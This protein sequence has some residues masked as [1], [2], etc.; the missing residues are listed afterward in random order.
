MTLGPLSL[1]S[2]ALS[3]NLLQFL[4]TL[5]IESLYLRENLERILGIGTQV[6]HRVDIGVATEGSTVGSAV[7]LVGRTVG[8]LG[9]LTHHTVTDDQARTLL[10]CLGL[11]DGLADLVDV[12]TVNL[13]NEPA[14]GFIL[15][16]SVLAGHHLCTCRELDI[17]GVIEHDQVVETQVT[18]DTACTLR[19][20]LLHTTVG[21]VGVDG[22]VHHVAQTSLQEL[23]GDGSTHGEAVTLS[24][25]TGC[26]LDTA[27]NLALGVTGGH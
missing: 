27:L 25:G 9:T 18:G 5:G 19:D 8:L 20:L 13:L 23:S 17:I 22:L 14:P 10:L 24:E 1:L 2:I 6:L 3:H 12:V 15:L 7:A 11:L 4:S 16:G 26:V 21:D